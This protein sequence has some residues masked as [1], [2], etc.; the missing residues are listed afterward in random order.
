[1]IPVSPSRWIPAVD[2][3]GATC[4]V[5]KRSSKFIRFAKALLDIGPTATP[6]ASK[7]FSAAC[8]IG[9]ALILRQMRSASSARLRR[10]PPTDQTQASTA[11]IQLRSNVAASSAASRSTAATHRDFF[12]D[13]PHA[14]AGQHRHVTQPGQPAG[15]SAAVS[16][17]KTPGYALARSVLRAGNGASDRDS[18]LTFPHSVPG[19]T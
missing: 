7:Y 16:T 4:W 2:A 3:A 9:Q 10:S 15:I 14:V 1:M 17:A 18:A 5:E 12:T 8:R 13:K 19:N 11:R 6:R